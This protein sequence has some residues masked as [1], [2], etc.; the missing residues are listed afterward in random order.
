MLRFGGFVFAALALLLSNQAAAQSASPRC[1]PESDYAARLTAALESLHITQVQAVSDEIN[2]RCAAARTQGMLVLLDAATLFDFIHRRTGVEAAH[3]AFSRLLQQDFS[4][5]SWPQQVACYHLMALYSL[6]TGEYKQ[7][8]S[9]SHILTSELL[10]GALDANEDIA[11]ISLAIADSH[12]EIEFYQ[13]VRELLLPL[14]G[15]SAPHIR[16]RA[17]SLLWHVPQTQ[18]QLDDV[19]AVLN[20]YRTL[21]DTLVRLHATEA[22]IRQAIEENEQ[23]KAQALFE[24]AYQLADTL[25][26][27]AVLIRLY[28][29]E[30]KTRSSTPVVGQLLAFS[31]QQ[32]SIKEQLPVLELDIEQATAEQ[33]WQQAAVK[34]QQAVNLNT[35]IA[36]N[37]ALAR[38]YA[39]FQLV[40]QA[41]EL[42]QAR[43]QSRLQALAA[44]QQ[45]QQR[46][47]YLLALISAILALLVLT[48]LFMK[49]RKAAVHFEKLANT[50][51]LTQVLNRRAIQQFA[52]Q[53]ATRS[54]Q[55]NQPFVVALAD[56]DHFKSINDT[57]GHDAG[58]SVLT[59]FA[60][61]T[62]A[63][64]R[65]QDR[66]GRW[67]GEEWLIVMTDTGLDAI[68]GLF[69]RMQEEIRSID[70]GEH[71][72]TVTFSMG[73]VAGDGGQS[74]EA[75]VQ[76]A[77]DLL[78]QAKHSG[79]NRLCKAND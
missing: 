29:L 20:D 48:L 63:L 9:I 45:N 24:D 60:R 69:K 26:A 30:T 78:Y 14:L 50:D 40:S 1:L 49:K 4:Q 51:G 55:L 37:N 21:P 52:E 10:P 61:R 3:Q 36:R 16:V 27:R 58:D 43:Q 13:S 62:N 34:L 65:Q 68:S 59:E 77:D 64:I 25:N 18:R 8:L 39:S 15:H 74:I 71:H 56:I 22:L 67:G 79:R 23:A 76:A 6:H 35:E 17:A 72:L 7:A 31:S 46:V 12:Y 73:A 32:L 2:Q 19:L 42:E 66:L 28:L 5:L 57:Y 54:Q 70:A 53:V 38:E 44:A 33:N 75:L 11:A 47:I 41:R